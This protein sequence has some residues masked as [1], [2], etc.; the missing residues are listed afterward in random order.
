MTARERCNRDMA[1]S[2]QLARYLAALSITVGVMSCRPADEEE[3]AAPNEE[4]VQVAIPAKDAPAKRPD[5]LTCAYPVKEDD[6]PASLKERFGAQAR[7]ETIYGP[8]GIELS[9]VALW[10]DDPQRRVEVVF[11]EEGEHLLSFAGVS[12]Q[13]GWRLADLTLGDPLARA[14]EVN[15][16]PFDLWGF[17]WDYGG[18]A[19]DLKG[20]KLAALPGGCHAIVRFDLPEN[21]EVSAELQGEVQLSSDDPRLADVNARIVELSLTFDRE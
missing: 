2:I 21:A 19:S 9:G 16:K 18:Y 4:E 13:S 15:G 1:T 7:A 3:R 17:G 12:G 8:E 14:Q 20:G 10:P 6:T 11:S 5:E